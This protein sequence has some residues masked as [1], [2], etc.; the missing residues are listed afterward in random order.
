MGKNEAIRYTYYGGERSRYVTTLFT[1]TEYGTFLSFA[2]GGPAVK[3]SVG[4]VRLIMV[5]QSHLQINE[6]FSLSH[7]DKPKSELAVCVINSWRQVITS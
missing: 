5:V 4:L 7:P 6:M 3:R 1:I 2:K